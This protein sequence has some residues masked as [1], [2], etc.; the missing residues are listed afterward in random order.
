MLVLSFVLL[1]LFAGIQ[2]EDFRPG[3]QLQETQERTI[4]QHKLKTQCYYKTPSQ[5]RD[6]IIVA[7]TQPRDHADTTQ[8]H[9]VADTTKRKHGSSIQQDKSTQVM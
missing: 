2:Y 9:C 4:L 7:N 3:Q 5:H 8:R 6:L 1:N